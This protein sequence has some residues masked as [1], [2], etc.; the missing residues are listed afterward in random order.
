[1]AHLRGDLTNARRTAA[2]H[3]PRRRRGQA[4]EVVQAEGADAARRQADAGACVGYGPRIAAGA[5][6][7]GLRS[8]WRS[9][10]RHVDRPRRSRLGP[11]GRTARH[12]TRG[13]ACNGRRARGCARARTLRRRAADSRRYVEQ[14]ARR[15][16]AAGRAG[17]AARKSLR[18]RP[19]DPRWHRPRARDRRRKRL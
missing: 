14:V 12:R 15:A 11:S 9:G 17:Y 2:R 19:R 16:D 8:S 18:L 5:H 13:A 3:R 10:T 4:H 7:S 6:P 1:M